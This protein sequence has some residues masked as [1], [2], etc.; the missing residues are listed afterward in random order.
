MKVHPRC[1]ACLLE[2]S[3]RTFDVLH[4]DGKI[5][6]SNLKAIEKFIG[7]RF[8]EDRITAEL[9]TEVHREVKKITNNDP[10]KEEKERSNRAALKLVDYARQ[11]IENA[12]DS[13]CQSFKIAIAG[14]LIDFGTYYFDV[15][16]KEK[17][18]KA[19]LLDEFAIDEFDE[20]KRHIKG[21][22]KILYLCD[23]AGEIVF[24]RLCIEEIQKLGPTVTAVVKSGA[25]V[26]D[27]TMEDARIAHLP[28]ICS[29]IESGTDSVGVILKESSDEFIKELKSTDL[30]IA[31]G[32][33][34]FETME[35]MELPIA[36]L[37]KAKCQ[38]VAEALGV[39]PKSSVVTLSQFCSAQ[40]L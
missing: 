6:L 22:K 4:I 2:Q 25:I 23:N 20:I 33:G 21:A 27:A 12:D 5:R 34:H 7:E 39:K 38:T 1:R 17:E 37:L 18:L 13:L 40:T 3:A 15:D 10:F 29:V 24:D 30:I 16:L 8:T 11:L 28:E 36:F 26:N 14:N 9:G 35:D 31:K 32:Q 19:A